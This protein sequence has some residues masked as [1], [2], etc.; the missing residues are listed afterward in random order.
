MKT[1]TPNTVQSPAP[2][3]VR[4]YRPETY[5]LLLALLAGGFTLEGVDDGD[6]ILQAINDPHKAADAIT[7]VDEAHLYVR[8]TLTAKRCC[9][10]I[11]LG[12]SPGELV[13]DHSGNPELERVVSAEAD[14]WQGQPQPMIDAPTSSLPEMRCIVYLG[15]GAIEETANAY[16]LVSRGVARFATEAERQSYERG[17][18]RDDA[19]IA[20][21]ES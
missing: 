3:K 12:N 20:S 16:I 10:F 5:S 7:A 2:R 18:A 17:F 13:N 21:L 15:D 6:S 14:K 4:D 8:H 19:R 9:L 1:T 11:V